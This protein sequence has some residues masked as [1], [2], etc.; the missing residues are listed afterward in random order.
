MRRPECR[1]LRSRRASNASA[2]CL[3]LAG[4]STRGRPPN[5]GGLCQGSFPYY[6]SNVEIHRSARKHGVADSHVLH[7]IE[8]ALFDRHAG[9]D[10]DRWLIIGPDRAGNLLEVV[11]LMTKEGAQIAIHAMAVRPKYRRLLDP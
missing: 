2:C 8:H 10:P 11:V 5:R 4:S 7:A 9:E 6:D 3:A 1:L